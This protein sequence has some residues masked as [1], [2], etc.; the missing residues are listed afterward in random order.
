MR[1]IEPPMVWRLRRAGA[2]RPRRPWATRPCESEITRTEEN[3]ELIDPE[4]VRAS[5]RTDEPRGKV[6]PIAP[7]VFLKTA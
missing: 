4:G 5:T 1:S 2:P 7:L 6:T 3:P